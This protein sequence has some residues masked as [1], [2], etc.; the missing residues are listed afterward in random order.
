MTDILIFVEDT[1]AAQ[2]VLG[3]SSAKIIATGNALDVLKYHDLPH[4]A[5]TPNAQ[6]VEI[7]QRYKPRL[8]AVGT[9]ENRKSFG[10]DLIAAARA[11][12]IPTVGLVDSVVSAAQRFQGTTNNPK[13][14]LPDWLIVPDSATKAAYVSLGVAADRITIIGYVQVD[15]VREASE[16][17]RQQGRAVVR[18]KL[19]PQAGNRPI[20]IFIAET[21]GGIEP[22]EYQQSTDYTLW[23]R[24]KTHD[25]TRIVLE[26]VLDVL[27]EIKPRPYVVLR[28]HPKNTPEEFTAYANEVDQMSQKEPSISVVFASDFIVG[29]TST[30]MFEAAILGRPTLSII[31]RESEKSWLPSVVAG[32]TRQVTTR[33]QIKSELASLLALGSQEISL[34]TVWEPGARVCLT[35]S[36]NLLVPV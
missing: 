34:P 1:G 10:L 19:F 33:E 36:L 24:G 16:K 7:L 13:A 29:M 28:L 32:V 6:A 3:L 2:M 20:L 11:A 12:N 27:S 22:T 17:L 18:A 8:V 25:R 15:I 21:L 4:E 30:L 23:G 14:Y 35:E 26:E 5:L 9:G 31:P